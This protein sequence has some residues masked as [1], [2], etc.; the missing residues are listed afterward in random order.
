MRLRKVRSAIKKALVGL[1][2]CWSHLKVILLLE[3]NITIGKNVSI[4]KNVII[5]TTDGGEII[6]GDNVSIEA[7]CYIYAQHSKIKIGENSFI[8][9]GSQIVAKKSIVIGNETLISAYCVIRDANHGID[10][11]STIANQPHTIEEVSIGDDVWLGT[12]CVVTVGC[13][14]AQG[15]IVGANAVV[16]KNV[17]AYTVVGGVPAK[18]IKPRPLT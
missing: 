10:T 4:G 9:F 16:T 1:T 3:E 12:H 13:S 6:I 14:V 8:G 2:N 11:S 15:A 5:K 17:E 18:Y 7:N